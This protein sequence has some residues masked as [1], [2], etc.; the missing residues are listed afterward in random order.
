MTEPELISRFRTLAAE[1]LPLPGSGQTLL[2]HQRLMEVGREDLTLA[3]LAE[4]HWDAVAILAEA[5]RK[6]TPNRLYGV[7]A[8]EKP[9]EA[10]KLRSDGN[11]TTITGS[12][13]FCSGA[14][15]IDR[16]LLTVGSPQELLLEVDLNK[17]VDTI[18]F[19][20]SAWKT[21]AFSG[22][23]TSSAT[24]N[25]T[26][27]SQEDVVGEPGWYSERP[28]F[29]HGACGP[30]ACWAGGA[31]GLVDFATKQQ[32][33]D[34]H[35][36]AHLGAMQAQVWGLLSYLDLAGREI[37][38]NPTNLFEAEIR[39]LS[40]R[41]LVEEACTDVLRRMPRA[42]GPAPLAMNAE[43]SRRYQELDL[44]LRQSHAERDLER[45]GSKFRGHF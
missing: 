13:M 2:R 32:R 14:G 34:P 27:I 7:W 25:D 35:T 11:G 15:L 10:L 38:A 42:Y 26:T 17:N 6:P 39:A 8:S 44:Y 18:R 30:A 20:G 21:T 22:S 40:L 16:V 24:F 31:V 41:H 43:I 4:A 28:G 12:K 33:K 3:R 37:D 9:G 45:L 36:L 19:D 29:W 23:N 5:G 1:D